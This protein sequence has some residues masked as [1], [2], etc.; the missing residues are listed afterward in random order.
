MFFSCLLTLSLLISFGRSAPAN[1]ACNAISEEV[2]GQ[3]YFP[4]DVSYTSEILKYW[5]VALRELRPA[6]VVMPTSASQVAAAVKILNQYPDVNF[7]VKSGGHDPNPGHSSIQDGVLIALREITGTTHDAQKKL[8]YVKP[9]GEWNDVIGTLDPMGVTVVGGRL[10]IVGIAG[11]LLQGG[12]SFLSAQYGLACDS[13]VGWETVTAN[14]SIVNVNAAS[15]PDLAVAM[16]GS[17]SQFGIVTQFTIKAHP[18]GK[19]WGG[20]RVY[21]GDKQD[22][23]FAA[24]HRF[25]PYGHQDPKAA[26]IISD[27]IAVGKTSIILVFY[28]YDGPESPSTGPFADFLKIIPTTTLTYTQS[29]ADL[30]TLNGAPA[31]IVTE[32]ASFRTFTIPYLPENPGI[33]AEIS[34]KWH[35]I[36]SFYFTSLLHLTSECSIDF[37]PMPSVVGQQSQAAGGNAMGLSGN[38]HDRVLLE[39]QCLWASKEDDE[40]MYALS[41]D[42]T[43]WLESQLPGWEAS[44]N[45][46]YNPLFMNDATDDQNVTGSYRDH[47]KFKAL[48]ESADPEGFFRER[49][50]GFKY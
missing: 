45:E 16:R 1:D 11:Y 19:V 42:L 20:S 44:G 40:T 3:V 41:R 38:D 34:D 10:G 9:G 14:G 47:A 24:L 22:E 23:I 18:I 50:G 6:C 21:T 2:P 31:A 29:Y 43:D 39:I 17:G 33:Y 15:Q 27:V 46:H 8:A 13:I 32:R 25:I 48:Q 4:G 12:I 37:Q 35:N 30:L 49:A 7:A 5:S 36:T 28:F 26:I